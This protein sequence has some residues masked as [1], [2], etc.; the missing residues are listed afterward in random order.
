VEVRHKV[1]EPEDVGVDEDDKH[2]VGLPETVNVASEVRLTEYVVDTVEDTE[3]DK[4]KVK[5]EV[6]VAVGVVDKHSENVGEGEFVVDVE[7]QTLGEGLVVYSEGVV[8]AEEHIVDDVAKE[9]EG[10]V[11]ELTD[12]ELNAREGD[13][14]TLPDDVEDTDKVGEIESLNVVVG[15]TDKEGVPVKVRDTVGEVDIVN[16]PDFVTVFESVFET[17]ALVEGDNDPV[18]LVQKVAKRGV[19]VTLRVGLR[20]AEE[21]TQREFWGEPEAQ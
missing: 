4:H 16:V 8:V 9:G 20:E 21:E 13:T 10:R 2:N 12:S 6:G 7:K 15:D 11:V 5:V 17:L 14:E 18:G 3:L 1:I 19:S